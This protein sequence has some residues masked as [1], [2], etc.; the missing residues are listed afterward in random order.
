MAIQYI[1]P[2]YYFPISMVAWGILCMSM[3]FVHHS[4][5]LM[6]IRFFQAFLEA[7]TFPGV[8]YILGAWYKPEELGKRTAIFTSSGL[9]GT[10]FSGFLQ[11]GIYKSINGRGGLAGWRWL[12]I[13][14][15]LITLPIAIYGFFIFPDT[16]TTTKAKYLTAEE[17]Q[18]AIERLPEVSKVR[19]EVGWGVLKRVFS[20]WHVYGLVPVRSGLYIR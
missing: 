13:V 4:W 16:P 14:D 8:H 19:G 7:A 11:G 3:A 2:R 9:A 18:L 6:V 10:M 17:K 15:F 1:P 5:Q 12:F 20:T